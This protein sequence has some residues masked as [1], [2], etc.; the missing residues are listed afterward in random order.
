[1][2]GGIELKFLVSILGVMSFSC[3]TLFKQSAWMG[4]Y[5]NLIFTGQ[6]LL[7][8]EISKEIPD[9][10]ISVVGFHGQPWPNQDNVCVFCFGL[11]VVFDTFKELRRESLSWWGVSALSI[12]ENG[13]RLIL[14]FL[15]GL[16]FQFGLWEDTS[17]MYVGLRRH[18][19]DEARQLC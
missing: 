6:K 9:G 10:V 14:S 2:S 5:C 11:A 17:L 8:T 13:R 16:Y 15:F 7:V 4:L 3:D 19:R 18:S 1:M 12:R